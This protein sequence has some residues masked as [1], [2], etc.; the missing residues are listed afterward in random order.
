MFQTQTMWLLAAIFSCYFILAQGL[1]KRPHVFV[2]AADDMGFAEWSLRNS[3]YRTPTLDKLATEGVLLNRLY[4]QPSCTMS[5][6]A[7][8]TGI[9]PH[10]MGIENVFDA[11]DNRYTRAFVAIFS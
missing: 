10:R 5:R 2:V 7:L 9:A 11:H 4:S 1:S 6:A 8:L 3:Q